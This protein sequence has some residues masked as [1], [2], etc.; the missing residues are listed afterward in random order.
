MKYYANFYKYNDGCR[1]INAIVGNNKRKLWARIRALGLGECS[2]GDK[3]YIYVC[4]S[5]TDDT[6]IDKT[7][8]F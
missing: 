1:L 5:K 2:R 4:E 8:Q 7:Y 6:V 3:I